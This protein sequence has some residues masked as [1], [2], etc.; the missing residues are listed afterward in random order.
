MKI[1]IKFLGICCNVNILL[2]D[3]DD[4]LIYSGQTSC[5]YLD[6]FLKPYQVYKLVSTIS[7]DSLNNS[8]YVDDRRIYYFMFPSLK[9]NNSNSVTF[10]LT[11]YFYP[12][13]PIERGEIILWQE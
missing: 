2:Y 10:Y 12:G 9:I 11:D 4:N 3:I 5:G 6:V 13:M 1:R 8:F 7:C